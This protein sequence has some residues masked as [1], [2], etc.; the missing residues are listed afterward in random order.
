M[1]QKVDID[2]RYFG[3]FTTISSFNDKR[4]DLLQVQYVAKVWDNAQVSIENSKI[5][6]HFKLQ[7]PVPIMFKRDLKGNVVTSTTYPGL[8]SFDDGNT[9]IN[10]QTEAIT[11]EDNGKA[12]VYR[13]Y[14]IY[15][16]A[17]VRTM[18]LDDGSENVAY[19]DCEYVYIGQTDPYDL[20][21]ARGRILWE[22][23]NSK[24]CS[25]A[26]LFRTTDSKDSSSYKWHN[27]PKSLR[28]ADP[29]QGYKPIGFRITE[30]L[31]AKNTYLGL[32]YVATSH[33]KNYGSCY[34]EDLKLDDALSYVWQYGTSSTGGFNFAYG[35]GYLWGD[36]GY[37]QYGPD[38]C[39]EPMISLPDMASEMRFPDRAPKWNNAELSTNNLMGIQ[40][41]EVATSINDAYDN[42]AWRL[43][44]PE[45]LIKASRCLSLNNDI[46]IL[47]KLFPTYFW[48]KIDKT[49]QPKIWLMTSRR[50]VGMDLY[51]FGRA[52]AECVNIYNVDGIRAVIPVIDL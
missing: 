12:S 23:G 11:G 45:E 21:Q 47:K 27:G 37:L 35:Y 24:I 31:S 22:H 4:D 26:N 39:F 48:A 42:F 40:Y 8:I 49:K 17:Y 44:T 41:N 13:K 51:E 18:L 19:E 52:D 7:T 46:H 28:F 50:G 25:D 38:R 15:N 20:P 30:N 6:Y 32:K 9:I 33:G 14:D 1:T 29:Y 34:P 16:K 43:P 3:R 10:Y 36:D 5:H 2:K